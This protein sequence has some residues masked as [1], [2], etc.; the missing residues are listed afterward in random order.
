MDCVAEKDCPDFLEDRAGLSSLT[1]NERKEQVRKLKG[2]VCDKKSRKVCCQQGVSFRRSRPARESCEPSMGSCLPGPGRCGL[3]ERE[4][5]RI[6]GGEVT[7]PGEFPFT[8]ILGRKR[9]LR[10]PGKGSTLVNMWF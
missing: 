9:R 2:R 3:E 5:Q 6:V 7:K 4:T 8:A 1:G 10:V